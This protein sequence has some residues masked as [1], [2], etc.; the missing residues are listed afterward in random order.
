MH[1]REDFNEYI[2]NRY[3]AKGM[4]FRFSSLGEL[5]VLLGIKNEKDI[6]YDDMKY[7]NEKQ[8]KELEILKEKHRN[9]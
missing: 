2:I 7:L 5:E 4:K 1:T 6:D 9:F 8:L 3:G